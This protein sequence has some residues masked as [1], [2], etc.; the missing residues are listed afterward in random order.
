MKIVGALAVAVA[1]IGLGSGAAMA[2]TMSTA[3]TMVCRVAAAGET[4]NSMMGSV[5]LICKKYDFDKAKRKLEKMMMD[6]EKTSDKPTQAQI[7]AA[8]QKAYGDMNL[9]GQHN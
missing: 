6:E 7:D 8:Y 4:S 9:L 5:A 1:T 3:P 2:Q